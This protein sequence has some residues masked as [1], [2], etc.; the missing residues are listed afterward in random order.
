MSTHHS[1]SSNSLSEVTSLKKID[2]SFSNSHQLSVAPLLGL[3]FLPENFLLPCWDFA[4]L[5][6]C[7]AC[8]CSHS[9]SYVQPP[10]C[11]PLP[12]AYTIILLSFCVGL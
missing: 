7:M 9:H 1:I 8:A 3:E 5:I 11:H 12:L 6:L 2:F 10:S 4:C